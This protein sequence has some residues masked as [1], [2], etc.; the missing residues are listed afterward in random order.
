[1]NGTWVGGLIIGIVIAT[2]GGAIAGYRM[3]DA[4]AEPPAPAFAEV[5]AV[6]PA[7]ADVSTERE[8]CEDVEVTHQKEP[9]DEHR[10]IG[11]ATGAVIGGVLG[12][13]VGG[14]SGKKV[15]TVV[16]AV[17]GGYAGNKI[18]QRR[19]ANDTYTTVE[20]HC[21]TVVDVQ[22]T[23]IGYDVTYRIGA[24]EGQIRMDHDPGEQIP[25]VD[26]E[27]APELGQPLT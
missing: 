27:L 12:N 10:V 1:M 24:E 26:G 7:T 9:R 11:T 19:Q 15:A 20:Q 23:V 4:P 18:Q 17:A 22:Q 3:L 6:T 14:G 8:A 25:L 16:G 5:L 13:Q 21:E 2:A